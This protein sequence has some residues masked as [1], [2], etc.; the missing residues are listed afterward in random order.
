MEEIAIVQ[1]FFQEVKTNIGNINILERNVMERLTKAYEDGTHAAADNL[2]CGENSWDYK[3]LLLERLGAYEDT[4]LTPE[5]ILDGK[6]LTGWIPVEERL[7]GTERVLI[8]NGEF[9][10]EGYRRPDGVWKYG[11]KEDELFS[12]LSSVPVIAWMPLPEP[13]NPQN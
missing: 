12:S 13:L 3:A 4:G 6:M 2:P 9:V 5:E 10:I 7:P 1:N 8:T 11:V